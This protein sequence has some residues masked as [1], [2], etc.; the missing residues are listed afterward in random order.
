MKY[1]KKTATNCSILHDFFI[2]SDLYKAFIYQQAPLAISTSQFLYRTSNIY[3]YLPC[4][5][6]K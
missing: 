2:A 4:L 6:K 3:C 5:S 1:D